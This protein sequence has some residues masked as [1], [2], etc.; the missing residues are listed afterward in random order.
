MFS[1]VAQ[2]FKQINGLA[3]SSMK[4]WTDCVGSVDEDTKNDLLEEE[5]AK[6]KGSE[7]VGEVGF[8]AEVLWVLLGLNEESENEERAGDVV[9]ELGF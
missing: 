5:M 4:E 2:V 3:W 6:M 9:L 1:P 8:A 7:N